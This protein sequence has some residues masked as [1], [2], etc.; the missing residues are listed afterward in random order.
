MC[1]CVHL[2][3]CICVCGRNEGFLSI[4]NSLQTNQCLRVLAI[5]PN[6]IGVD[7]PWCSAFGCLARCLIGIN[8]HLQELIIEENPIESSGAMHIAHALSDYFFARYN[9]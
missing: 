6:E 3:V 4:V 7:T 8:F 9:Q 1:L 5:G 2:G